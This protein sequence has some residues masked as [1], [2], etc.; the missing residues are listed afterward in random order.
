MLTAHQIAEYSEKLHALR[1]KLDEQAPSLRAEACHGVGGEDAGGLSNAPVHL[2]DLGSQEA[3]AIVNI[4][5]A[6]NEAS[7]RQEIEEAFV[8]LDH[9]TFG[10][11]EACGREIG[12]ERLEAIPY[13]RWCIRCAEGQQH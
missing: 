7:L 1:A 13:S 8:R 10:F 2:G 9:G 11:C 5:L 6:M 4:G 12:S 3:A